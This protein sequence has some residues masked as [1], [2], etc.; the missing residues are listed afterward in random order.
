MA[1][2]TRDY[3]L[4]LVQCT[5]GDFRVTG[6]GPDDAIS[7]TP[8]SD[9]ME[10]APAA[11]GSHVSV[12]HIND[13]RWEGTLKLR[14]GT[15]AYRLMAEKAQAQFAEAKIGAVSALSFQVYDPI[16]GDKFVEAE[17]RFMREPDMPFA[18][19]ASDAEFKVL[20]SNPTR[21]YG[22]NIDTSA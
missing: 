4:A 11:D 21:T 14:R 5:V 7:L 12:S 6:W 1:G 19:A 13:P 22:G 16:S 2:I 20:L 18:K 8:M 9:A 3:N 17:L 10:S 15:A